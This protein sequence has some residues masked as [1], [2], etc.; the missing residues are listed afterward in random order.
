MQNDAAAGGELK[1]AGVAATAFGV[2]PFLGAGISYDHAPK[3]PEQ[4]KDYKTVVVG[5]L[6]FIGN[7]QVSSKDPKLDGELPGGMYAH[8]LGTIAL[9]EAYGLTTN[10]RIKERIKVAAQRAIKYLVQSQHAEGGWRYSPRQAGDT[11]VVAWVFLAIRS[12]QLAGLTVDRT[13]LTKADKFLDSTAAG[14]DG[15][16]LSRYSYLPGEPAKLSLTPAGLLAR[17]YIGWEKDNPE[18]TAGCAYLMQNL[19]PESASSA[20]PMY[21]YYYASQVLHHME[22]QDWDKWNHRMREHLIRTQEQSGEQVG[23]WS[24]VG[25]DYGSRGGRMYATSLAVLSLEVYYRHLPLY[26]R[27]VKPTTEK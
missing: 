26:R 10:E 3:E 13:A 16:K 2:L 20:G 8:A 7:S 5:G 22:G 1:E 14:P 23:S 25:V 19:P 6:S 15:A 21:Y 12:G 4:L 9:C 24:P 27:F 18:L 11:S 17:Q